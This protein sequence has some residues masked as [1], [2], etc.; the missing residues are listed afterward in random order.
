MGC[1]EEALIELCLTRH[2]DQLA[3][4]KKCWEGRNDKSLFDYITKELGH[5][6]RHLRYLILEILKGKR[7]WDGVPDEERAASHAEKLHKECSKGMMQDFKED[8]VVDWLL[9]GPPA[10]AKLVAEL[11]EKKHV[12]R[13]EIP[14]MHRGDAAHSAERRG[15]RDADVASRRCRDA[16]VPRRRRGGRDADVPR[17]R[18]AAGAAATTWVDER[19][20]ATRSRPAR[21]SGTTSRC[22]ARCRRSAARSST[23][24]C[25]RCS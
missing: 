17:R 10:E 21:A 14:L 9:A 11:Y 12:R 15:G 16:D 18:V 3:V 4:G 19:D 22:R 7:T 20:A 1:D 8:K 6:Y 13:A 23:W 25:R 5:E 2:P 24:L